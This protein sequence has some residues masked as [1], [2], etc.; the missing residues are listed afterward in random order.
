MTS[1]GGAKD[2]ARVEPRG[3]DAEL[4]GY[5]WIPR[6]LDKARATLAETNG[7]YLFGCPVD[8]TCMARL[9]VSPELVLELARRHP[10]DSEWLNALRE[11]GIPAA[12][13]A[14]FDGQAVE[15]ELQGPGW[16]LRVSTAGAGAAE[17][18]R[19][20]VRRRA[21]SAHAARHLRDR[22]SLHSQ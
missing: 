6:M 1:V 15:D 5:A 8:H 16:Y 20:R 17:R 14:W 12:H 4:E 22:R 11:H 13:E 7:S 19:R 3:L 9:G 10:D 18:R 21:R 2:L